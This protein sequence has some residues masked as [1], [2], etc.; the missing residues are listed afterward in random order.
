M[1]RALLFILGP[2]LAYAAIEYVAD[3]Y[4]HQAFMNMLQRITLGS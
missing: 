1:K 2:L 3:Y 4:F